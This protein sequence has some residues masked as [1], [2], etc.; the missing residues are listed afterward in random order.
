MGNGISS[1]KNHPFEPRPVLARNVEAIRAEAHD[2]SHTDVLRL[3]GLVSDYFIEPSHP[4]G[5]GKYGS[6]YAAI[7]AYDR[8]WA[9]KEFCLKSAVLSAGARDNACE[10]ETFSR[11][12]PT[13]KSPERNDSLHFVS[14]A[15]V[16]NEFAILEDCRLLQGAG[17]RFCNKNETKAYI[18]Q[19]LMGGTA[20]DLVGTTDSPG[21]LVKAFEAKD[22]EFKARNLSPHVVMYRDIA[23]KLARSLHQVHESGVFVSDIKPSNTLFHGTNIELSDFGVAVRKE[24]PTYRAYTKEYWAPEMRLAGNK[25][26]NCRLT[27]KVDIY[28]LGMTL[29]ELVLGFHVCR[30]YDFH[31]PI[32]DYNNF[33]QRH[34]HN[35]PMYDYEAEMEARVKKLRNFDK[36]LGDMLLAMTSPDPKDR[37]TT[38]TII[39]QEIFSVAADVQAIIDSAWESVADISVEAMQSI[40]RVKAA[41][42]ASGVLTFP[43][44]PAD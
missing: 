13:M 24:A 32:A 41:L 14:L 18:I 40:Q 39:N 3:S 28:A 35:G 30:G 44:A 31:F 43:S 12:R 34:D 23:V 42:M 10:S 8:P 16:A 37:P 20:K 33:R 17:E 19:R 9:I 21:P 2:G 7:D 4:I 5:R 22:H 25:D 1:Q 38:S 11:S 36:A 29:I 26:G 6:I 27:E 15:D